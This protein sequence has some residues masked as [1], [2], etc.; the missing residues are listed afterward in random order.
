[1]SL[2]SRKFAYQSVLVIAA[3]L[4]LLSVIIIFVTFPVFY[5]YFARVKM[6]LAFEMKFCKKS[7]ENVFNFVNEVEYYDPKRE[8]LLDISQCQKRND[9]SFLLQ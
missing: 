3:T 2:Y 6:E 7:A 4:A 9:K 1:M 5:T 8:T